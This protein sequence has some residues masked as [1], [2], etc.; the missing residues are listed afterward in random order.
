[1]NSPREESHT[2]SRGTPCKFRLR[3]IAIFV[4][5]ILCAPLA[6][7]GGAD[8]PAVTP[9][10]A[11]P[12]PP[13]VGEPPPSGEQSLNLGSL[14]S[15]GTVTPDMFTGN[16]ALNIPLDIGAGRGRAVV[17]IAPTYRAIDSNSWL[18]VGWSLDLPS[19]GS[20]LQ[21][22][23]AT[24]KGKI[25]Y[26]DAGNRAEIIQLADGSFR[27]STE[28]DFSR[29][30]RMVVNSTVSWVVESRD[31][32]KYIF[33][34]ASDAVLTPAN[35]TADI[36]RW[37]LSRII[38]VNGNFAELHYE[39]R[40]GVI[41]PKRI[42]LPGH[43]L[44]D[45]TQDRPPLFTI[46]F[47][48]ETRPDVYS[49]FAFGLRSDTDRRLAGIKV[50]AVGALQREFRF[51][52]FQSSLTK[53]SLLKKIRF[54]SAAGDELPGPE[55]AYSQP[56]KLF[57]PTER[58][59]LLKSNPW[60]TDQ[61][62]WSGTATILQGFYDIGGSSVPAFCAPEAAKVICWTYANGAYQSP[63]EFSLP[64]T[65][66]KAGS[67]DNAVLHFVDINADGRLDLC[68]Q[69]ETGVL[70]FLS[71]GN[72]FLPDPIVGPNWDLKFRPGLS[73]VRFA[74]INGDGYPDI[75][76]L[77]PDG[78]Q[79]YL[80]SKNGFKLDKAVEGPRWKASNDLG[81][82]GLFFNTDPDSGYRTYT[83]PSA[84]AGDWGLERFY[85]TIVFLDVNGDGLADVCG[86]NAGGITCSVSAGGKPFA[87]QFNGPAWSDATDPTPQ[88]PP[89][90]S[91]VGGVKPPPIT[92]WGIPEHYATI[93]YPDL[94]GDGLPDICGRSSVG[95]VC[96]LN[97]GMSFDLTNP[98]AGP[99][100]ADPEPLPLTEKR[101]PKVSYWDEERSYRSIF[102]IDIN[103]DGKDDLCMRDY[104]GV[105]C[106]FTDGQGF[107]A[108]SV[109]IADL[110][111]STESF[112]DDP[113]YYRSLR[114]R[115]V[116]GDG[117]PDMC[118]RGPKGVLC[119]HNM[120]FAADLLS[121]VKGPL[122]STT[123]ISYKGSGS[124]FGSRCP[125]GFP[126]IASTETTDGRNTAINSTF[127]F[128]GCYQRVAEREFRGFSSGSVSLTH[129]NGLL[130]RETTY[131][132]QGKALDPAPSDKEVSDGSSRG[133]PYLITVT[134]E[135]NKLLSRRLITYGRQVLG[136]GLQTYTSVENIRSEQCSSSG[137]R[138][139]REVSYQR[140]DFGNL[141]QELD[142]PSLA[143]DQD[144]KLIER[145]FENN[146]SVWLLGLLQSEKISHGRVNFRKVAESN[147]SYDE[148][149]DCNS[150]QGTAPNQITRGELTTVSRWNDFFPSVVTKL[151]YDRFGNVI[152]SI[153]PRGF[154]A[155]FEYDD[156]GM[157]VLRSRNARG[158]S[159]QQLYAGVNGISAAGQVYGSPIEVFDANSNSMKF[160]HDGFGRLKTSVDANAAESKIDYLDFGVSNKQRV[161]RV[162]PM[163]VSDTA[164]FD[165]LGRIYREESD[166]TAGHI[167]VREMEYEDGGFLSA[168]SLPHGLADPPVR[169]LYRYD[170]FGRVREIVHPDGRITQ[171]CFGVLVDA[172]ID[173]RRH[174]VIHTYDGVGHTLS[175]IE[176]PGR[177]RTCSVD[178]SNSSAV[179]NIKYDASG[180]PI[181]SGSAN[182]PKVRI[183]Y[184][185]LDRKIVSDSDDL[186]S[187]R[188]TYDP[189]GNIVEQ[190]DG[191]NSRWVMA[192]DE[193][194]RVTS[195][196]LFS[197]AG[198]KTSH[199]VYAYD[200]GQNAIGHLSSVDD[201]AGHIDFGYSKLGRLELSARTLDGTRYETRT[202]Y[203]SAGRIVA[204][205]YPDQDKITYEYEGL[206]L[207]RVKD[208]QGTLV[209]FSDFDPVFGP[210]SI[211]LGDNV[212]GTKEYE[213]NSSEQCGPGTQRL[214]DIRVAT[215]LGGKDVDVF[216][217]HLAYNA[218][219]QVSRLAENNIVW[220]F[221]YDD[222]FR[223]FQ[224]TD[225]KGGTASWT[226]DDRNNIVSSPLGRYRY[227]SLAQTSSSSNFLSS[228]GSYDFV[229]DANGNVSRINK[230][231][232][233][234]GVP[235]VETTALRYDDGNRIH[236]ID[237]VAGNK[238]EYVY[239]GD[240]AVVEKLMPG[241][242]T[243]YIGQHYECQNGSCVKRLFAGGFFFGVKRVNSGE[244]IYRVEDARGSTR[245]L[246]DRAGRIKATFDFDAY[247]N[248]VGSSKFPRLGALT[249]EALFTGQR[250]EETAEIYRFGGRLYAPYVGRYLQPDSIAVTPMS[251]RFG[252]PYCY[253]ND[254]PYDFVDA[255]GHFPW[256]LAAILVSAIASGVAE[257]NAGGDFW[258][259]FVKGAIIGGV[260]AGIASGVGGFGGALAGGAA[261][262]ALQ[263]AFHHGDPFQGALYG[264]I[265]GAVGFGVFKA[266][267]PSSATTVSG[268]IENQVATDALR[269]AAKGF[270]LSAL[271]GNDPLQGAIAQAGTEVG[272]GLAE[273]TIGAG[274]AAGYAI[275]DGQAP[276]VQVIDG[277]IVFGT[278]SFPNGAGITFGRV[279]NVNERTV[280]QYEFEALIRANTSDYVQ[281]SR[282]TYLVGHE[283]GHTQSYSVLGQDFLPAY[284][285][286]LALS[287]LNADSSPL[288]DNFMESNFPN[289]AAGSNDL[290]KMHENGYER[291]QRNSPI[292]ISY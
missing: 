193:L 181:E 40:N 214:C 157:F 189:N 54:L 123:T 132:H 231:T 175:V 51:E 114:I 169:T 198:S 98:V 32:T 253:A 39:N 234:G 188:Y 287:F 137:C 245:A 159:S 158:M 203:D 262:G 62:R 238:I 252:N 277:A 288:N 127:D 216:Y 191:R 228:A 202:Q 45:G 17:S 88:P 86:R 150:G 52:Y 221:K 265:G 69:L 167:V 103:G 7:G 165:G 263:S 145:A 166:D 100:W 170:S 215:R 112:W 76:R 113:E 279:I 124:T 268:V 241:Q 273:D 105:E 12:T 178:A 156:D 204:L 90:T 61:L 236:R 267:P 41:Y 186:G 16:L 144:Y 72:G 292:V 79:C 219:G 205:T 240:G 209:E 13:A 135:R 210:T 35:D 200:S 11:Q 291:E 4:C 162:S 233:R 23:I 20:D 139:V 38:D 136:A 249:W 163:G 176:F 78:I 134:D 207:A 190:K 141:T 177:A 155:L 6:I 224:V 25:F 22:R 19:I 55:F 42:L 195:K 266:L 109:R 201:A 164:Y 264:A 126:V 71:S 243:I 217:E 87:A 66:S 74:D 174:R 173:S 269:G 43:Q 143:A 118:I 180:R 289:G 29:F 276:S 106:F 120:G 255:D 278:T 282:S 99:A 63:V 275:A 179:T 60:G 102:Y 104:L 8:P 222:L 21:D 89:P 33:G 271:R 242:K 237:G 153:N 194:D 111:T 27:R 258:T 53:R 130:R 285:A 152:C 121:T 81:A 50:S 154:K 83:K 226:Y 128:D 93:S 211:K 67:F 46:E 172:T 116:N 94:N 10:P 270:V 146:Q 151:I 185:A 9:A 131:F 24:A 246:L 70:C 256:I 261:G 229:P 274:F 250:Y 34:G 28:T 1:M 161:R 133:K 199:V 225:P 182:G 197:P 44:T 208:N 257:H 218:D 235:N 36:K 183:T 280:R 97:I 57:D 192:Y 184:D 119:W 73:T 75:C 260:T 56:A 168:V 37:Y 239:D 18:G 148:D 206:Y 96:F 26:F 77:S 247:G 283:V 220:Q 227:R 5:L 3:A 187:W 30:S 108:S 281:T 212:K 117:K 84:P 147:Y 115:D 85:N 82:G 58:A 290:G 272:T 254:D 91:Y 59:L 171:R 15:T 196:D 49:S 47:Q 140:D 110:P 31:G 251:A 142:K 64:S 80:G 284:G 125:A 122:G 95:I 138:A 14:S 2:V 259:G 230:H 223:L 160:S 107:S 286:A 244:V 92:D 129:H 232:L 213:T 48:L 149:I 248:L 65:L 68:A 101:D